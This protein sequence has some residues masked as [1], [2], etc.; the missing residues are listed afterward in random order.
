M[1][2]NQ[3]KLI[4]TV[5]TIF[6]VIILIYFLSPVVMIGPGERGIV[7]HFGAV[8]DKILGEGIHLRMPVVENVI[9]IDVKTVKAEVEAPS[10]SKDLQNVD[11]RIALN[12]HLDASR[13]N[14]LW[15]EIGPQYADRIIA[16][17]IQESVKAAT[18][19]FTAAELVSLRPQV[20]DEIK[21]MLV[22]RLTSRYIIVDDFSIV[23][24]DFSDAYERAIEEKQV[25]QQTAQKAENDLRR[26][27]I[28]AE[29]RIAQAKGEAEAIRIQSAALKENQDL[30][31]L[32]A[33][34]KWDGVLPVYML[35]DTATTLFSMDGAR[36]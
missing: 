19:K 36:K 20:K 2:P 23:N 1:N 24:F 16:P 32:E 18:A 13:V 9:H 12:Y 27:Q 11:T 15:Q 22:D 25:A 7:T 29:Q 33:V 21:H 10:F 35:G 26:I 5:V 34:K 8:Q 4:S 3:N 28:E 17:T 6:V 31:K 14:K 30:I